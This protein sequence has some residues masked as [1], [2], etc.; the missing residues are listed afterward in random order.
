MTPETAKYHVSLVQGGTKLEGFSDCQLL[1][2][3][4]VE[5][6]VISALP[7]GPVYTPFTARYLLACLCSMFNRILRKRF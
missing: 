2:E 5:R 4:A 6:M 7:C 3:A 1:I